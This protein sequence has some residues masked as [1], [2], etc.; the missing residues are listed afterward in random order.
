MAVL[1]GLTLSRRLAVFSVVAL[2]LHSS[3]ATLTSTMSSSSSSSS[4]TMVAAQATANDED[5]N[6]TI[7]QT[8]QDQAA[9]GDGS[10]ILQPAVEEQ[11]ASTANDTCPPC[12]A[13]TA[14]TSSTSSQ[15]EVGENPPSQREPLTMQILVV[16]SPGIITMVKW[17][18]D[19]YFK[20]TDGRVK[21]EIKLAPTMPEL[22]A[23]IEND[24]R[25]GGGLYDAYYTNPV[26]LGTAAMLNGFLDLTPFVK[27][28]PYADWIDVL[29][30]LR[31]YV[32]SFED[33]IYIILLDGDTHSMFYRKDVLEHYG[34]KVPRTWNEYNE[35]AKA[36]HGKVFNGVELSGSC[37]SRIQGDHAMYW[38]HLVLSTIT[39]TQGTHQGSLFDSKDMTPLTGEALA[40]MLRI[41]EEQAKYGTPDEYTDIINHVQNGH[42]NDGTCAMTFMWGDLFRRSNAQGSILHDKLGIAPTPG[43]EFVLDRSTGQLVRCTRELCPYAKYYD[44]LGFVNV[45]PYAANGGWGAAVSANTDPEK[46]KALAEFFLWASSR[47]QAEQY[48]IPNATLP[49]D[50]INGQDPWRKSQLDVDKWVLRGFQREV[51]KQYVESIVSN[52]ISKNVVVEARFPK[53]GEIMSVL[54]KEVN[55]YLVAA[56][57][58]LIAEQDKQTDR[59][60]TAQII[61]DQWNQIIKKYNARGD[62]VTPILEIYQRLRGVYVPNEE[63]NL[64]T[65]IRPVGLTLMAIIMVS[66]MAA[67]AW[68]Y[69]KR[70]ATVVRAS[71]PPFLWLICLGTM[72]LGSSILAMSVDDGMASQEGCSAA[73]MIVPWLVAIGFSITFAALAAKIMRLKRLMTSASRFQR[74]QVKVQD[75]LLP[76][77][78]ILLSNVAFLLT[79]TLADPL[80]WERVYTGRTETGELESYGSCIYAGRV[81]QV[82][83]GFIAGLNMAALLY[84]NVLAYQT[85]ELTVAFNESKFVA[86]A[87]ASILQAVLI[88]T[89]LLFLANSNP[90]ARY[91]VRSVLIFVVCMSVLVFVFVPKVLNQNDRITAVRVSSVGG[92]RGS[93]SGL[94]SGF[95]KNSDFSNGVRSG[96]MSLRSADIR[97]SDLTKITSPTVESIRQAVLE[98][99]TQAQ[100]PPVRT[101]EA[102]DFP[103]SG[104]D[105]DVPVNLIMNDETGYSEQLDG[106]AHSTKLF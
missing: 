78:L 46:Q 84:A 53:A 41:H 27:S 71:Q 96:E 35:V 50:M 77:C 14:S 12:P 106:T 21:I 82:M 47:E 95:N 99:A 70:S 25:A 56:H 34:L 48:V 1:S 9:N 23:E 42:M 65:R 55:E 89:P 100:S 102:S 90:T 75:V 91:V 26:V 72:V 30:A 103:G 10:P 93:I 51:S 20:F 80:Y 59:L 61:T 40:E 44:D 94:S 15:Y 38:Y 22:F 32:M 11:V 19:D 39:Q 57:E 29:P 97:G 6:W 45:A 88:G 85:R 31:K 24:A 92:R 86:L 33:K 52:L 63:K 8:E 2:L 43:S 79:W 13:C 7:Y 49:W 69:V 68:V 87:M 83:L 5:E 3:P 64:L 98:A 101:D 36:I 74:I 73:C 37:V 76:F 66:S 17:N 105:D 62:T 4:S 16:D 58:G 81:S 104:I 28:S 18:A 54:D 60:K 67:A